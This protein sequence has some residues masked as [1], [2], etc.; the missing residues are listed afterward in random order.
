MDET[1]VFTLGDIS[2]A[3]G[4]DSCACKLENATSSAAEK[5]N[6][7]L[8]ALRV[9]KYTLERSDPPSP[10]FSGQAAPTAVILGCTMG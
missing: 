2:L 8:S 3:E 9:Q 7:L 4:G 1:S 10:R 6:L 5:K